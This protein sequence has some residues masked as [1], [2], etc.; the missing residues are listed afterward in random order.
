M[1]KKVLAGLATMALAL[2]MVA[3]TATSASAHHNTI[4]AVITCDTSDFTYD[5]T[6]SVT[7]S[8][9][10]DETITASSDTAL[11]PV[12]TTLGNK[13]T[14]QFF[15][16]FS[17]P[18]NKTLTLSAEWTNDNT[19]TSKGEIKKNQFPDCA[20]NHVPVT[21][22][23]ATP[24]DTA[25]QG[26]ESITIDDDA[27]VKSGHNEQHD[28]DII[29]A[30]NYWEKNDLGEWTL[31][32]FAGKN[33][34]TDFSGY[35]GS[36]ILTAGCAIKATPNAPTFAP[37][38]CTGPGTSGQGSYTIPSTSGVVYSVRLNNA[39]GYID[40]AANTYYV[41]IGTVIDVKATSTLAFLTLN[42]PKSWNYTVPSPGDCI[43]EVTPVAPSVTD[44]TECGMYGS[45]VPQQT[46]G[47]VYSFT[48][49]DGTEG[50]WQVKAVPAQG[51]KF[52]G[53]QV[54][55]YN[56][57][58]GTYT[59]CVTPTE[60]TFV[61]SECTGPGQN[62]DGSYT[63]PAKA[64][65]EYWVKIG[66]DPW[67]LAT[68]GT[69]YVSVFPTT[70]T[71]KAIA[72]EGY[73]LDDY[74]GPWEYT[75]VSPGECLVKA[76]PVA[77]TVEQITECGQYGSVT[78]PVTTG[79]KYELTSGTGTSG[80][81]TVTATP[82]AGF[83]FDDDEDQKITYN[84]DLG[85]YTECVTALEPSYFESECSPEAPLEELPLD[86]ASAE[87]AAIGFVV[88]GY[89]TIP[90][91][92]GVQYSVSIND[93]PFVDY[94][95]GDYEVVDG[96][97]VVVKATAMPGY[98]L[99]GTSEWSHTFGLLGECELPTKAEVLASAS[100]TSQLC[101]AQGSLNV[102]LAEHVLYFLGDEQL[103]A[104]STPKAPGTYV[105]TAETDS[106]DYTIIGPKEWTLTITGASGCATTALLAST[107]GTAS[108]LGLGIGGSLLFLGAAAIYM[109]RRSS[110]TAE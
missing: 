56:G 68:A 88:P 73:T 89:F 19:N 46:T 100:A 82:L 32:Y 52:L 110:V 63:I 69:S 57:N 43:I 13:E 4:E 60:P 17:V 44:I 98:T 8:E 30:F 7:N 11:V 79:V 51:Y 62:S 103:T 5:V 41:P 25:A 92:A 84:G 91:K 59:D 81:Y 14:K 65:V 42:D 15:E 105:V 71:I 27:I 48:I 109:R 90:S 10:L 54:V 85:V 31:K 76:T 61:P 55:I 78:W 21:I 106:I 18:T 23:H 2:G 16:S 40:T 6:W 95:A 83:Y 47:V 12:G 22:C 107:G 104:A 26:W 58:V 87:F 29:P 36:S 102:V 67:A 75:F 74:T 20:P 28:L 53:E 35:S 39:G 9:T 50:A 96:D 70:V 37:A 108:L 101:T 99:E 24:P 38:V 86:E 77:P 97:K 3:A 72:I 33:L 66:D 1:F 49:G 93:G 45:V 94:S 34:G 64:G 80:L